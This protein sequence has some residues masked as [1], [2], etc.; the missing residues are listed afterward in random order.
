[1]ELLDLIQE[2]TLGMDRSIEKFDPTKGYRFS[3]YAYWWIRQAVTRAVAEKSRTVRLPVYIVEKLNQLK[4]AQRQLS[5]KLGRTATV[6]ELAQAMEITPNRC[7][8]ILTGP[9]PLLPW[10]QPLA[11][12]KAQNWANCCLTDKTKKLGNG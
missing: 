3:T 1:M 6:Q 9:V 8:S 12:T 10:M 11:K 4:K 5:Q 2:G 7:E